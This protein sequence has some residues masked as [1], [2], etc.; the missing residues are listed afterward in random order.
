MRV[1]L[2]GMMMGEAP[3]HE[4]HLE[5]MLKLARM[6]VII[7]PPWPPFYARPASIE[8]LVREIAA[9]LLSWAGIEPGDRMTRWEASPSLNTKPVSSDGFHQ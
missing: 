8:D 2:A 5:A 4:G 7:A 9:R 3:L 1:F 6:G